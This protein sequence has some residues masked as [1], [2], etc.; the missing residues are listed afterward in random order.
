MSLRLIIT[1]PILQ[2]WCVQRSRAQRVESESLAGMHDCEFAGKGEDGSLGGG[3]GEL[4][5]GTANEGDDRGGIDDTSCG[6]VV[7]AEC[8]NGVPATEPNTFYLRI[9]VR[10]SLSDEKRNLELT[11]MLWV[12][13]QIFSGVS[14]ASAS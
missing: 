5:C 3:I 7:T 6:L 13:S 8:E 14:T 10:R 12:K 11:L 9:Q 2:Q 1:Q 4:R